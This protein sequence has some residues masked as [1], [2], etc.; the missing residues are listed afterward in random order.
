MYIYHM[1]LHVVMLSSSYYHVPFRVGDFLK[2]PAFPGRGRLAQCFEEQS[3]WW[4]H[5]LRRDPQI[6][7]RVALTNR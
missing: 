7:L 3:G 4:L 1:N 2:Q 6:K 5:D